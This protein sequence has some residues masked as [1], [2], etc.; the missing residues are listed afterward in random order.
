MMNSQ[1]AFESSHIMYVK[2][3]VQPPRCSL[4]ALQLPNFAAALRPMLASIAPVILL[5]LLLLIKPSH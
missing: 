3:T 2:F 4:V 1:Y 5:L